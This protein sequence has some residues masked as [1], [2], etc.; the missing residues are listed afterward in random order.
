MR[1]FINILSSFSTNYKQG[2][3][4]FTYEG[5]VKSNTPS[6]IAIKI[7]MEII[8]KS[9]TNSNHF[10]HIALA[11]CVNYRVSTCLLHGANITTR[12]AYPSAPRNQ[13]QHVNVT[14]YTRCL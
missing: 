14:A 2:A 13:L 10:S 7:N 5:C 11:E 4:I 3:L 12:S 8:C 1:P 6:R 9:L